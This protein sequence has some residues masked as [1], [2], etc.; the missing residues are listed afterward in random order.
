[1]RNLTPNTLI[2]LEWMSNMRA[3]VLF[4][5]GDDSLSETADDMREAAAREMSDAIIEDVRMQP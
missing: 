2:E 3:D 5:E 1:M 4:N